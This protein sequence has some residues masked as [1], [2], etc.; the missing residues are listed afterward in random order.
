MLFKGKVNATCEDSIVVHS[1]A[2]HKVNFNVS[3]R[4]GSEERKNQ[5]RTDQD[6]VVNE[7]KTKKLIARVACYA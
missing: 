5:Q 4:K 6:Y 7:D 3:D 2:R 1:A